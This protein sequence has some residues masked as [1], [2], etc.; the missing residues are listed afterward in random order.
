MMIFHYFPFHLVLERK[1][2]A[3][4]LSSIGYVW[5]EGFKSIGRNKFFSMACVATISACIF[6]FGLFFIIVMNMQNFVRAAE[7]GVAITIF[8]EEGT[9][10]AQREELERLLMGRDDVR[11]IDYITG[12]EAWQDFIDI[13]FG[14]NREIAGSFQDAHPLANSDHFAV[15]M[16]TVEEGGSLMARSRNISVTQQEL[17]ELAEGFGFVRSVNRSDVVANILSNVNNLVS[18]I[19]IAIILILFF[20]SIFLISNTVT[21]GITV[22]KEEIAIMKYIGAKDF[23]VR[24][25][26]VLEGLTFGIVG[27]TIP[28]AFLYVLYNMVVQYIETG[29]GFLTNIISFISVL[30][31]FRY[32]LP[33]GLLLGV[34][35]GFIGS[36][37]T[38]RR[39]LR[40]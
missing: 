7:E 31:L 34:G 38:V 37:V 35:I 39:H 29:Y 25:P 36:F 6:L 28:L 5:S 10:A 22:R 27:A 11:K 18:Y 8:F 17:V 2:Y 15:F 3:M 13:Y 23:V 4:K 30:Q 16:N 21:T 20:V 14:G 12:D 24:A 19:S 33:I 40:V 1:S 26:F 32:L 9:Q